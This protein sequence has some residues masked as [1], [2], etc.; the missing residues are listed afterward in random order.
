M[1]RKAQQKT[2]YA[3]RDRIKKIECLQEVF[4]LSYRNDNRVF[5]V[6]NDSTSSV[7]LLIS[8]CKQE[9]AVAILFL[10]ISK[11]A[12]TDVKQGNVT[13]HFLPFLI[14]GCMT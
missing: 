2:M 9:F 8:G 12:G 11:T 7:N 1:Y 3:L 5:S 6:K 13:L 14:H 10:K 4:Q